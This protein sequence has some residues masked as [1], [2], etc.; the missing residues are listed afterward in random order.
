MDKRKKEALTSP[1]VTSLGAN[2]LIR[3]QNTHGAGA[4]KQ[5]RPDLALQDVSVIKQQ[6]QVGDVG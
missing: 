3:D 5:V 6:G 4:G 1:Q 2:A